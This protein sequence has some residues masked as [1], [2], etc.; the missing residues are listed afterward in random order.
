MKYSI[1]I[2][3]I[4]SLTHC[5]PEKPCI[6][7]SPES[8]TLTEGKWTTDIENIE[9]VWDFSEVGTLITY[10]PDAD[11]QTF[12]NIYEWVWT[13]CNTMTIRL[14]GHQYGNQRIY[15]LPQYHY[16]VDVT[17][18]EWGSDRIR[19]LWNPRKENVRSEFFNIIRF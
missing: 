10:P 9:I 15:S 4:L 19:A 1:C 5:T 16:I 12:L 7:S 6:S 2:I 11:N 18:L 13:D 8:R 3:I 14:I 17:I